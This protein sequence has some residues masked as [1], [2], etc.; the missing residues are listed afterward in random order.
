MTTPVRPYQAS[1]RVSITTPPV[2]GGWGGHK[3]MSRKDMPQQR[4][5]DQDSTSSKSQIEPN[6]MF[7]KARTPG[8]SLVQRPSTR[9]RHRN[10]ADTCRERYGRT[11][12][13]DVPTRTSDVGCHTRPRGVSRPGETHI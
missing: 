6:T 9:F 8:L 11:E 3:E 7:A 2:G 12:S 10:T 13:M 1:T 4:D 5:P